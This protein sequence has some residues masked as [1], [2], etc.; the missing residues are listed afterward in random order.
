M[1]EEGITLE[2]W[3]RDEHLGVEEEVPESVVVL[4]EP[5]REVIEAEANPEELWSGYD[6]IPD[7]D[8]ELFDIATETAHDL[9]AADNI[10]YSEDDEEE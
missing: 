5:W 8:D 3:L 6:A 7:E 9:L 2:E 1:E 4:F 10:E